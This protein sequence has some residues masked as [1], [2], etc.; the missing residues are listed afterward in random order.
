MALVKTCYAYGCSSTT[1]PSSSTHHSDWSSWSWNSCKAQRF[2]DSRKLVCSAASTPHL[3]SR[4]HSHQFVT[5]TTQEKKREKKIKIPCG[6]HL[7]VSLLPLLLCFA[8]RRGT[9]RPSLVNLDFRA[10]RQ[11]S[12][13]SVPRLHSSLAPSPYP[14][15]G[16]LPF[17]S[18][19]PNPSRH[20]RRRKLCSPLPP[21]IRR[22]R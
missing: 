10:T 15:R 19:N 5:V 6:P 17:P 4:R 11:P 18:S 16:R 13:A 20:R 1:Y 21:P 8:R 7:S 14:R 3:H 22:R 9:R 12:P 2:L